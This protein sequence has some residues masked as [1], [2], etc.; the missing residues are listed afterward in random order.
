MSTTQMNAFE[1]LESVRGLNAD[2]CA[3]MGFRDANFGPMGPG[4]AW[5][6]VRNGKLDANKGRPFGQKT[7]RWFPNGAKHGLFNEDVLSDPE[8]QH[9]PVVVTEGEFDAVA[10]VQSGFARAVSLPD[11]WVE[12]AD[13]ADSTKMKHFADAADRM[14]NSPCVILAVDADDVGRAFVRA[15]SALLAPHPVRV[16]AWPEGCKDANDTL[17]AYGEGEVARCINAARLVDPP[18]GIITGFSDLPPLAERR[19]LRLG[20]EPF[21]RG[22]AFEE[23]AMSVCTGIPGHGKST[24]VRWAA[25]HLVRNEGISVGC[26]E[27]EGNPAKIRDHLCRLHTA[28]RWVDLLPD[29]Q[30]NLEAVLDQHWR[31]VH[32]EPSGNAREDLKWLHDMVRALAVRDRCKFIYID[33][34]NELEHL[35]LPGESLTNYIN[36]ATKSIRQWAERYDTHICVVA[37]PKKLMGDDIADGYDIADSAAWA[38]KPALGFTVW[39]SPLDEDDP[40]VKVRVWK[41]RDVEAYGFGRRTIEVDFD[42][43]AM[44][45][46]RRI[47]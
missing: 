36:Y 6:Y 24:F 41:V 47:A 9:L 18:G 10:V 19:I 32:R 22:L 40:H 3:R 35:P 29:E 37:H 14:I 16:V 20:V 26:I 42:H 46:R 21:D 27:L 31:L 17:R 12:R 38:N 33:P 30:R 23:C 34:W 11:G 25:H 2:L 15:A 45:Y 13:T 1:W 28:R 8:L 39:Q 7:F 5:G 4:V 43:D 44:V